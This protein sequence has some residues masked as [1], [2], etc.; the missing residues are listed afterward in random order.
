M[1]NCEDV[2]ETFFNWGTANFTEINVVLDIDHSDSTVLKCYAFKECFPN[3]INLY[4]REFDNFSK[5]KQNAYDMC[6]KPFAVLIDADEI[7]EEMPD[8]G[9]ADFMNVSKADVGYFARYNLQGDDEHCYGYP[10]HQYRVVRKSSG[11]KMNGL[12][13]DE[14]LAIE[15]CRVVQMPWDIIHYGHIR[16]VEALKLKGKDRMAFA[17]CDPCDGE[18][19]KKHGEDWFIE[20]NKLWNE[21]RSVVP[22]WVT[23]YSRKY[24]AK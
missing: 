16:P 8:N 2:V 18:M 7:I 14:R 10:D 23:N 22:I 24:W 17:D 3:I 6:T 12:P 20:R 4:K 21:K 11:I 15:N 13:V 19:L 9:I 1:K 5:Q